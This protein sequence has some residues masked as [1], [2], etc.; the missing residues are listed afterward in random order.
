MVY[1]IDIVCCKQIEQATTIAT[2]TAV[3]NETIQLD[4]KRDCI[5]GCRGGVGVILWYERKNSNRQRK[6]TKFTVK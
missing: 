1:R 4:K 5:S 6:R 2:A 3:A